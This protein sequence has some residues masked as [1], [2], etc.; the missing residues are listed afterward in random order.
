MEIKRHHTTFPNFW[1]ILKLQTKK[2]QAQRIPNFQEKNWPAREIDFTKIYVP[3]GLSAVRSPSAPAPATAKFR[4]PQH[5][6]RQNA[7]ARPCGLSSTLQPQASWRISRVKKKTKH[8]QYI[9]PSIHP[10][11]IFLILWRF[12]PADKAGGRLDSTR[13]QNREQWCRQGVRGSWTAVATYPPCGRSF[14]G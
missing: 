11:S 1:N 13:R 3:P 8:P 7:Q 14:L 4:H 5:Q 12:L 6:D 10:S 2:W 9:H